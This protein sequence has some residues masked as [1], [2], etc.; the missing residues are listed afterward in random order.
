M[1][2]IVI[3]IVATISFVSCTT[4]RRVEEASLSDILASPT[5]F[6]G[7]RVAVSGYIQYGFENCVLWP[8]KSS[9]SSVPNGKAIWYWPRNK[10]CVGPK[11]LSPA[12]GMGVLT[13]TV[14]SNDHGHLGMFPFSFSDASFKL[15][16]P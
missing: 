8:D 10:S 7:R 5:N 14:R 16:Q 9:V 15:Q 13:G 4:F 12:Q 11:S 2:R 6:E 1:Q 3:A